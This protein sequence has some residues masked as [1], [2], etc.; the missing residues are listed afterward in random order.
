ME[1]KKAWKTW[2]KYLLLVLGG[3]IWGIFIG[4][5]SE[6]LLAILIFAYFDF[7]EKRKKKESRY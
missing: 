4:D 1:E 2:L 3:I 5:F 7:K 6:G